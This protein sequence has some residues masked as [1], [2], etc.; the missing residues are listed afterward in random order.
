[1][2]TTRYNRKFRCV[3]WLNLLLLN[4]YILKMWTKTSIM[5]AGHV[6]GYQAERDAAL[7]RY[8]EE[9]L[10]KIPCLWQEFPLSFVVSY[11]IFRFHFNMYL[12]SPCGGMKILHM[13]NVTI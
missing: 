8:I 13:N 12:V 6:H 11:G 5:F 9:A 4:I 2:I 7:S 1:V 10:R 3:V